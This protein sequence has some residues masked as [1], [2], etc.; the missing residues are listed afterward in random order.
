MASK[1]RVDHIEPVDGIPTGGGRGIIQ[2]VSAAK[3]DAWSQTTS[4]TTVYDV[5]GLSVTITPQ[6]AS[7]KIFVMAMVNGYWTTSTGCILLLRRNTSD[8]IFLGDASS[9][10]G[11]GT[12]HPYTGNDAY[13]TTVPIM[14][15]DSPAS[16]SATTYKISVQEV[17]SGGNEIM[18]NKPGSTS[19]TANR[20]RCPSSIT[21]MEVSA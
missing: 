4:G 6:S 18:I 10:R 19:D 9:S 20:V 3:T 2:V 13:M 21:V 12:A 7:N 15:M 16:T 14:Y 17:D 5:T 8:E 1:L 11:R